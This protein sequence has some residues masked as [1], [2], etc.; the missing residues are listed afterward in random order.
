MICLFEE[1]VTEIEYAK[2]IQYGDDE[3]EFVE[4][5]KYDYSDWSCRIDYI[6]KRVRDGKYFVSSYEK[7]LTEYQEGMGRWFDTDANGNVILRE[8][9]PVEKIVIDYEI[10]WLTKGE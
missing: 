9:K 2:R 3:Y 7:G 4:K 10:V 1:I 5:K 8:C 6:I